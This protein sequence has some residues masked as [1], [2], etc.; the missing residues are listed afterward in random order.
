MGRLDGRWDVLIGALSHPRRARAA[1]ASSPVRFS[2]VRL[3]GR[4][5]VRGL[6]DRRRVVEGRPCAR[7]CR[8][9]C[10]GAV[11]P[12]Q[13]VAARQQSGL[14]FVPVGSPSGSRPYEALPVEREASLAKAVQRWRRSRPFTMLPRGAGSCAIVQETCPH[15]ADT[16]ATTYPAK[17]CKLLILLEPASGLEPLTC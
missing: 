16:A 8:S 6:S 7:R 2:A 9:V 13:A 14:R 10:P 3:K 17:P 1:H 4:G 12:R 15:S 5:I 11:E